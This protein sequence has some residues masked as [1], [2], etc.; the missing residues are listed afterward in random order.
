[1]ITPK[2]KKPP[3]GL[4]NEAERIVPSRAFEDIK[5]DGLAIHLQEG[6]DI[7]KGQ[8]ARAENLPDERDHDQ[9]QGVTDAIANAVQEG[10]V[11]GVLVGEGLGP[12][13][14]DA[15]DDQ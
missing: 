15:V 11:D 6:E 2:T 9:G 5:V 1:M 10:I 7:A 14:D 12:S 13:E 4:A 3:A 8:H